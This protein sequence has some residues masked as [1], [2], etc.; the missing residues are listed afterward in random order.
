MTRFTAR[1]TLNKHRQNGWVSESRFPESIAHT[2]KQVKAQVTAGCQDTAHPQPPV[3]TG[4][5]VTKNNGF[6]LTSL[7]RSRVHNRSPSSHLHVN[8]LTKTKTMGPAQAQ[9]EKLPA[10]SLCDPKGTQK[11]RQNT[12]CAPTTGEVEAGESVLATG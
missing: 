7:S 4:K 5:S 6:A 8:A 11:T 3:A 9:A 12:H 10:G 1:P 2:V